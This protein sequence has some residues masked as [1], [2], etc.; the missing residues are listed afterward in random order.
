MSQGKMH[1][2]YNY[3][4]NKMVCN[5]EF[6]SKNVTDNPKKVTCQNCTHLIDTYY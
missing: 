5:P 4:T 2:R 1:L 6:E 3:T